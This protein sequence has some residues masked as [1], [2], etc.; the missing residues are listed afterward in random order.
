MKNA[1]ALE[2]RGAALVLANA[3]AQKNLV[4]TIIE[5]LDNTGRMNELATKMKALGKPHAGREIAQ[6]A[7]EIIEKT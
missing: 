1:R 6:L 2:K 5:L 7:I 3:Q 4:E